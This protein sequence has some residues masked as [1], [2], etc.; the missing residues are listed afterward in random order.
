[1]R[2]YRGGKGKQEGTVEREVERRRYL[3]YTFHL[4]QVLQ[5]QHLVC[6]QIPP[7]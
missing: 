2:F 1:M 5:I 6:W 7:E 4:D 3:L